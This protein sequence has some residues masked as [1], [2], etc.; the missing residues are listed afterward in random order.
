MDSMSYR[1]VRGFATFPGSL[2][3]RVEDLIRQVVSF[4]ASETI[5]E[6][7]REPMYSLLC[8]Y[9][10]RSQ[11][12]S[13]EINAKS[14]RC[15]SY[16]DQVPEE[17]VPFVRRE[18]MTTLDTGGEV[19]FRACSSTHS[20]PERASFLTSPPV[21]LWGISARLPCLRAGL[22]RHDRVSSMIIR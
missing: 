21:S 10:M 6:R 20:S 2:K 19:D 1:M 13:P 4:L 12:K 15:D 11:Q 5:L 17:E 18:L 16:H 3:E 14:G 8:W 9:C 7:R 22:T